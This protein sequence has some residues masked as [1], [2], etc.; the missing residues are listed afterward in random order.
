MSLNGRRMQTINCESLIQLK[1][2]GT[3]KR[4]ILQTFWKKK[5][6]RD[7][8]LRRTQ[9]LKFTYLI[10]LFNLKLQNLSKAIISRH[11]LSTLRF[12]IAGGVIRRK[13]G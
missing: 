6:S 9:K 12:L 7:L 2:D 8:T 13:G 10:Y 3:L 11:V 5:D 1:L 4:H